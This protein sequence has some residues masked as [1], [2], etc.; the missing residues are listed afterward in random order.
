MQERKPQQI[1]RE[2]ALLSLSQLPINPKKLTEEHLPKLVL[3]TVRTLRSEVQDTLDNATAELQRSNERLLTSQTRASDLD[4][5]RNLLKEAI[6]YTQTAINQLGAAV[7]FPE[8][9][10]L[11]NQDKEVGRYAI[12]L[13]KIVNEHRAIIDEQISSALV[14]WQVTR[15]AQIDRDILRIAVGEMR[16]LN[17]PDRVAINEAVELAKRYSGDEGHRFINGVLRRV[18]EQKTAV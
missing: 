10:Q 9:I 16:F 5:A 12:Q 6:D 11:A 2:L 18:T 13:V 15:L 17:L 7:E 4:T 3:A 8:L 14:D 1:A